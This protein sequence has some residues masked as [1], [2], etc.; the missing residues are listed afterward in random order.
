MYGAG[1]DTRDVLE[2]ADERLAVFLAVIHDQG[3]TALA[4][5]TA[6]HLTLASAQ[7]AGLLHLDD[8]WTGADRL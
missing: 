5:T 8:V 7:L 3:A 6:S 2:S 1:L 4:V